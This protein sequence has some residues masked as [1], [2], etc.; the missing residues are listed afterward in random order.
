MYIV[1]VVIA[2]AAAARSPGH[3]GAAESG[4][5]G[6][7]VIQ[8]FCFFFGS[9]VLLFLGFCNERLLEWWWGRLETRP[10]TQHPNHRRESAIQRRFTFLCWAAL[11]P[12]R[13]LSLSLSLS[14]GQFCNHYC[15]VRS[16]RTQ[17]SQLQSSFLDGRSSLQA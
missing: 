12:H 4:G 11:T 17:D 14:L 3:R 8:N 6:D 15:G 10:P 5:S 2:A 9:R 13:H 1:V 7:A 16:L